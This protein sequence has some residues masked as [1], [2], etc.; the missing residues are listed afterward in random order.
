MIFRRRVEIHTQHNGE[1]RAALEDDF[2]HF[3][4]SIQ[5]QHGTV[6]AVKGYAV[7]FPFTACPAAAKSLESLI[8]MSLSEIAHSV[9]RATDSRHQCTHMLDLAGL[10]IAAAAR[11]T[12]RRVYDIA[13]AKRV[14]GRTAPRL[15]RD[16]QQVLQ[17]Q[18]QGTLI[19]SPAP[20]TGVDLNHGMAGWAIKTL[21]PEE[22]EAALLLRRCTII[23]RGREF[24]LDAE[25][26]A[27]N[28]GLCFAQQPERA[29]HALRMK[30]STQDFTG[31]EDLLCAGDQ[32]WLAGLE[33]QIRPTIPSQTALQPIKKKPAK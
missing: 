21:P 24:D 18:T 27:R 23:S 7:R 4:V 26:H 9:T 11:G 2:H 22:A 15:L 28:T 19:E 1:V 13:I 10:A 17:W 20:Y 14:A 33:D 25:R 12:L 29:E 32:D 5:H 6:T 3:R 8:G 31:C 16:G 30:G